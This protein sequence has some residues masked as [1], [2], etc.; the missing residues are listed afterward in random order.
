MKHLPAFSHQ[1]E[2]S[3]SEGG[4]RNTLS[5]VTSGDHTLFITTAFNPHLSLHYILLEV[6]CLVGNPEHRHRKGEI[7]HH[8]YGAQPSQHTAYYRTKHHANHTLISH[9][10]LVC[11]LERG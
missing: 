8:L 3:L 11:G 9:T 4:K 1:V 10:T 5:P 2:K 7:H 6:F